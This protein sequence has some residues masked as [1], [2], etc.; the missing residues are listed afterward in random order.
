LRTKLVERAELENLTESQVVREAIRTYLDRPP[1]ST[2]DIIR[3]FFTTNQE[4]ADAVRR[5]RDRL[6]MT[7]TSLAK[8]A[9][10]SPQAVTRLESGE[11]IDTADMFAVLDATHIHAL[12]LPGVPKN[13]SEPI[14]LAAHI[15]A[16]V[17]KANHA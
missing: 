7:Q 6:G 16:Y 8:L 11:T 13:T 10:V 1:T 12:A 4:V 17:A 5:Q 15:A 3:R 2:D 9:N 14:D